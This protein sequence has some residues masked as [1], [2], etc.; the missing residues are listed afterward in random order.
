MGTLEDLKKEKARLLKKEGLKQASLSDIRARRLEEQ[1]IKAEIAALRNP[2]SARKKAA[3]K[4][5]FGRFGRFAKERGTIFLNNAERMGQR[6]KAESQA[7]REKEREMEKLRLK[8]AAR[9]RPARKK[10]VKKKAPKR[11]KKKR[12]SY[13]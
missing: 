5:A 11:R 7:R 3:V 2:D 1:K 10:V 4:A 9:R 12:S 13:Y 6:M 8:A